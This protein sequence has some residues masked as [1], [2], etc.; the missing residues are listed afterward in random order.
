MYRHDTKQL[1][2]INFALPFGGKLSSEN[3]WVI[4]AEIMPW[5]MI[6]EYYRKSFPSDGQGAPAKPSRMAFGT[7]VI[8]ETLG[9]SDEEVVEQLSENPYLQYF[10]GLHEFEF[11]AP[12]DASM[13][14]HF[15]KRFPAEFI[16]KVNEEMLFRLKKKD[17]Q[18]E[19]DEDSDSSDSNSTPRGKLVIDATC[20]PSDIRFPTDLSL[21]NEAREKTEAIID[22]LHEPFIGKEKKPRTYRKR[23]RKEYLNLAKSKKK[24]KSKLRKAMGKQLN[25]VERNLNYINDLSSKVSLQLL[26][27]NKYHDLLVI[28]EVY[29]Q[30]KLMH[31][32]RIHKVAD[33]IVSISQPHVRPIVRGKASASTEFGAKVS[34]SL[35]DGYSFVDRISWDAYNE[36]EDLISQA[37]SYRRRFGFFPASIHADKIYRNHENRRFCKENGIRLSGPALGRPPKDQKANELNK[38]I[39]YQDEIDRIPIEGKFGQCKR[40]F[41]LGRIMGKLAETSSSMIMMSFMVANLEKVLLCLYFLLTSIMNKRKNRALISYYN[42]YGKIGYQYR[43]QPV[44]FCMI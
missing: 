15:R 9:L 20:A 36:S 32:Q 1:E 11:K 23:A 19:T 30:Q 3:R 33:R 17:S 13:L 6:E 29:R 12:F 27:R 28:Q 31:D 8:K 25:Y 35:C 41:G 42:P 34:V 7:L 24:K 39:Q 22:V 16:S 37:Q 43:T 21:L 2:F 44:E 26:P 5:D 40:R 18:D 38:K 14:V 4:K 10:I